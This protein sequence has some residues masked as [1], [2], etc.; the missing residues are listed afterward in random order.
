M[1]LVTSSGPLG[2]SA[3]FP[4]AEM[5]YKTQA[6][7]DLLRTID[8]LPPP[9]LPLTPTWQ[10]ADFSLE[11]VLSEST[12]PGEPV[13]LRRWSMQLLSRYL[14]MSGRTPSHFHMARN[15]DHVRSVFKSVDDSKNVSR[16]ASAPRTPEVR[17]WLLICRVVRG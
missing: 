9:H 10:E 7:D 17:S 14:Y 3:I 1:A 12:L 4:P 15:P 8:Y 6:N 2:L 5:V 11:S 16:L 13:K